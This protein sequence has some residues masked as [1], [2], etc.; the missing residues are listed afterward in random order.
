MRNEWHHELW[1]DPRSSHIQFQLQYDKKGFIST[2]WLGFCHAAEFVLLPGLVFCRKH[3]LRWVGGRTGSTRSFW[4][5][6]WQNWV[7][8]HRATS[9]PH[10]SQ[11]VLSALFLYNDFNTPFSLSLAP[12]SVGGRLT[13]YFNF[14][15]VII[16]KPSHYIL[17]WELGES[18]GQKR[19]LLHK[20]F[21]SLEY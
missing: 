12:Y 19:P 17:V 8:A 21:L 13:R 6:T 5:C 20:S 14:L 15:S 1:P 18:C 3:A 10:L 7:G 9:R 11:G 16:F 4:V 2:D